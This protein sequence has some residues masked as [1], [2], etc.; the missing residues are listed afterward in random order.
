MLEH[1]GF[2]AL[3]SKLHK[4]LD[5]CGQYERKVII[6][7]RDTGVTS[8]EFGEYVLSTVDDPQ[9]EDRWAELTAQASA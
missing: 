4:A 1:I 6:T 5:L 9:M 3:G 8:S 2:E 7:G